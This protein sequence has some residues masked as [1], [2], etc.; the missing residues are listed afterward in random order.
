MMILVMDMINLLEATF[1]ALYLL[2]AIFR[3]KKLG[4]LL[5]LANFKLVLHELFHGAY[6]HV[7]YSL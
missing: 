4:T 7:A 5:Y 1:A 6:M 2:S 3:T